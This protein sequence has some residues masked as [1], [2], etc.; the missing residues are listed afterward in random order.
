MQSDKTEKKLFVSEGKA[1]S[2]TRKKQYFVGGALLVVLVGTLFAGIQ[3]GKSLKSNELEKRVTSTVGMQAAP[4]EAYEITLL[5]KKIQYTADQETN[6]GIDRDL[7]F[8]LNEQQLKSAKID[9][10]IILYVKANDIKATD[11]KALLGKT[12]EAR[13]KELSQQQRQQLQGS[14]LTL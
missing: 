3:I 1:K 13:A 14:G 5:G 9:D 4:V 2:A 8:S 7:L 6:T 12:L 10:L 11:P